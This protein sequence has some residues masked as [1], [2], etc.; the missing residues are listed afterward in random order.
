MC[1]SATDLVRWTDELKDDGYVSNESFD[2]ALK[3]L[4]F[5]IDLRGIYGVYFNTGI[6]SQLSKNHYESH[7]YPQ[8]KLIIDF[9]NDPYDQLDLIVI[10]I[11]AQCNATEAKIYIQKFFDDAECQIHYSE[12]NILKLVRDAFQIPSKQT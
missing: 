9:T 10:A 6:K 7:L 11:N 8:N 3:I 2:N 4:G 1:I 12:G 5:F